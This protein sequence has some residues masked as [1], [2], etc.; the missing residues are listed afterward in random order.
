[1]ARLVVL[2]GIS[3]PIGKAIAEDLLRSGY[4]ICGQYHQHP[5]DF[6]LVKERVSLLQADLRTS[7][8]CQALAEHALSLGLPSALINN[9]AQFERSPLQ[10]YQRDQSE[11]LL[12]LNT[13]APLELAHHLHSALVSHS[14][15]NIINVVDNCSHHRP[16]PQHSSYA[17]SKAA[18]V[19]ITRSLASE[20]APH[21]R[22]NAIGPGL[23]SEAEPVE[24]SKLKHKIPAERWGQPAE[25]AETVRLLLQGP[26]YLT[27]QVL[28]VD[29][30][31]STR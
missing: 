28:T 22:V 19:A 11:Q 5:P 24:W 3:S 12:A 17:A 10:G 8:G 4:D 14:P 2:T 27:G 25:I 20:L 21:V 6:H 30:G 7:D 31:W 16:W 15:G 1:M 13:L 29:G 9:A 26:D 18:L 23:I